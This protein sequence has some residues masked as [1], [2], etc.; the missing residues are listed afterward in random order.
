MEQLITNHSELRER[1]FRALADALGWVNA[2]R[3]LR[4]YD[5]GSGNYTEERATL[6]PDLS[7]EEL[8]AEVERIQ[9]EKRG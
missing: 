4:E 8:A 5:S 7:I 6:L 1:G 2:V 3:F 9:D